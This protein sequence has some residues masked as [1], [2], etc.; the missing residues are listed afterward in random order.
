MKLI[1]NPNIENKDFQVGHTWENLFW[2]VSYFIGSQKPRD[3]L[4]ISLLLKGKY[5]SYESSEC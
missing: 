4:E 1:A 5:D 3:R 2:E